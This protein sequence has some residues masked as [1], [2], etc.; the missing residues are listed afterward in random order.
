[1][2]T[3][4]ATRADAAVDR[5]GEQLRVGHDPALSLRDR[6]DPAICDAFPSHTEV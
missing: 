1:M 3:V 4:E 6:G 2:P 5:G